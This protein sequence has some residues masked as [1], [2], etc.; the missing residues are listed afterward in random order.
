MSDRID[1]KIGASTGELKAGMDQAASTVKQGVQGMQS[2]FDQM[3]SSVTGGMQQMQSSANGALASVGTQTLALVGVTLSLAGAVALAHKAMTS[4]YSLVSSGIGTVEEFRKTVIGASYILT[5]MSDV[6]PPD[7]S[8]AYGEWKNYFDWLYRASLEADKKSAASAKE[9]FTI[10]VELRKKGV[11]IVSKEDMDTVGRLTDLMKAVTPTYANLA[12]QARG[13]IEAVMSGIDRMGSQTAVVLGQID[14]EFKKNIA[15]ARALGT[16][17]KYFRKLLPDIQRYILDM[18]GTWDAVSAS[19]KSA[20][21]VV[22]IKAF[23][24]AHR[25][26]VSMV[27][28]MGE[29]L[30]KNGEL[31]AEGNKLAQALGRAWADAKVSI[32]AALDYL[33]ANPDQII[34]KINTMTAVIGKVVGIVIDLGAGFLKVVDAVSTFAMQVQVAMVQARAAIG[35]TKDWFGIL[36]ETAKQVAHGIVYDFGEIGPAIDRAYKAM[37]ASS[38]HWKNAAV[39]DANAVRFAVMNAMQAGRPPAGFGIM[40]FPAESSPAPAQP[41]GDAPPTPGTRQPGAGGGSAGGGAGGGSSLVQQWVR[42]LEQLKAAE[43]KYQTQSLQMEKA[44]YAKKLA[45]GQVA[46]QEELDELKAREREAEAVRL[47]GEAQFWKGKL[48]V[49]AAGSKDYQEVQH[50]IFTLEQQQNKTRLQ[51]EI[52]LIKGKIKAG[53]ESVKDKIALIEHESQLEKLDLKRKEQNIAH[54]AKM[55]AMSRVAELKE[56]KAL[57]QQ[58]HLIDLKAAK[59]KAILEK[60]DLKAYQKHLK[61]LEKLK[62]KHSVEMQKEDF[63]ITE[64]MKAQWGQVWN[65]VSQ[66]FQMSVQGIITGTTTLAEALNNI[67][68]NILTSLAGMFLQ[69]AL[70]YI[71]SQVMMLIFG[72]AAD[73]KKAASAIGAQAGIAGAA[74]VASVMVALPFPANV[75]AAPK[76]GFGAAALAASFG[77]LASAAGGW[78]VPHDTLAMVHKDEKILP[79]DWPEK[80]R[81]VAAPAGGS[82]PTR[83]MARIPITVVTPDGRTLLKANKTLFF[84]LTNQGIQHGEIRIDAGRRGRP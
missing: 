57:K 61:D 29:K 78:D 42:E 45:A 30:V 5:T 7:L 75:A 2:P 84:D 4:W 51:A 32:S 72:S 35:Y 34:D 46:T 38:N 49:A 1:V 20:W 22:Q 23:G 69:M 68:Q 47:Q 12:N 66:A 14:P 44:F 76:V 8:K 17:M 41:S 37:A 77:L 52:G 48:L 36:G 39:Q 59:D 63:E 53:Q 16:E 65:A 21:E 54:Q 33:L 26:V 15:N 81:A 9:I 55:G 79:A 70:E 27:S 6:K 58:E 80:L 25:D 67:W 13:E 64:A 73:K 60:G 43:E 40:G 83:L 10:A 31:T 28:Q 56:Y 11:A 19:M 50:K 62:E 3:R 18:M 82:G 71:A 74:G 24:D